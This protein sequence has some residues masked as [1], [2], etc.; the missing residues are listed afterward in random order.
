MRDLFPLRSRKSAFTL[1]ELLVVIAIIMV[2]AAIAFPVFATVQMRSNKAT[3]MNMMKQLTGAAITYA[4]QNNAELP[5]EDS[6]GTDTWQAAA[7]PEN[8]QA[9]YN[10]LPKLM[11]KKPVGEYVNDPRAFYTKDNLLYLPGATYPE[12]DKKLVRPLFAV[13][14]NTKLQRKDEGGKKP[15]LRMANIAEPARTVLFLEQ[16]LPGEKKAHGTQSKYDGSAKGSARSF[17]ARYGETGLISF[18]DG[19]VEEVKGKDLL[20]ETGKFPFPPEGIVWTRS[21]DEDPNK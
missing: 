10:A 16:G 19:H 2:L 20:T 17:V 6:K 5:K 8:S 21:A 9:W 7:D 12:N 1:M 3:A 15:P 11:G 18:V 14:I 4:A 13:A